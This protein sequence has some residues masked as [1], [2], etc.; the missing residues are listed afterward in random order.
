MDGSIIH[1]YGLGI[2]EQD[3]SLFRLFQP[4]KSK[5]C[6]VFRF[7][8]EMANCQKSQLKNV[9]QCFGYATWPNSIAIVMEYMAAGNLSE[10]VQ[11]EDFKIGYFL[12][13]RFCQEIASGLAHLHNMMPKRIVHGDLKAENVLLT[14]D[15]HCKIS[16]FGSSAVVPY[17]GGTTSSESVLKDLEY[18]L[19]YAAPERLSNQVPKKTPAL[20]TYSFGIIIFVV[21]ERQIPVSNK[22]DEKL[23]LQKIMNAE[24]SCL[25]LR[26]KQSNCFNDQELA[27]VTFLEEIMQRCWSHDPCD[28]PSMADVHHHLLQRS[29]NKDAYQVIKEVATALDGKNIGNK[30]HSDYQC[31]PLHKFHPPHFQLYHLGKYVAR[32]YFCFNSRSTIGVILTHNFKLFAYNCKVTSNRN[33]KL[34]NF[35]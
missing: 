3:A 35:S 8:E 28:R 11:D 34:S 32:V 26:S 25:S 9:V 10:L 27:V 23:F 18:T 17:T 30:V 31:S 24:R 22:N 14:E 16:D 19:I 5:I 6:S 12:R 13:L 2:I 20:D 4:I 33:V 15:L 1:F 7:K 29:A 21:L